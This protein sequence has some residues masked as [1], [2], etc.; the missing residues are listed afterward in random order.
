MLPSMR[1]VV[2]FQTLY[3]RATFLRVEFQPISCRASHQRPELYAQEKTS[4]TSLGQPANTQLSG[5]EDNRGD[6]ISEQWASAMQNN[7][8]CVSDLLPSKAGQ[9][10]D[11]W[12]C[13]PRRLPCY[14]SRGDGPRLAAHRTWSR[15]QLVPDG[16]DSLRCNKA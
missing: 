9:L 2:P 4:G 15:I 10:H 16:P 7:A 3:P 13:S 1:A 6:G 12:P 8:T 5:S 14:H 11:R